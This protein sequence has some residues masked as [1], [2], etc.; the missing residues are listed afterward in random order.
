MSTKQLVRS[1]Q[2]VHTDLVEV[3]LID[4]RASVAPGG[5]SLSW[6]HA[7]VAAGRAPQ[8]V[9]RMSRCTRWRLS[10]V[11]EFWLAFAERGLAD[12]ESAQRNVARAKFASAKASESRAKVAD[13]TTGAQH[14]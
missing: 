1:T 12:K 4:A 2:S 3:A 7:E 5:M 14:G 10:D 6:W 9:V 13:G 8:P 11:R